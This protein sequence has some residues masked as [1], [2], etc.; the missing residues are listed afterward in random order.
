MSRFGLLLALG[1]LLGKRD[2]IAV[3]T[4]LASSARVVPITF[5]GDYFGYGKYGS[6]SQGAAEL[7]A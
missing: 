6:G 3:S 5:A 2:G 4:E 1:A 7:S